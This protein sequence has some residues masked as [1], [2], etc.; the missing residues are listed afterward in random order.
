M[1][2]HEGIVSK[3]EKGDSEY[4]YQDAA[5]TRGFLRFGSLTV[6]CK[7]ATTACLFSVTA[8]SLPLPSLG[9]VEAAVFFFFFFSFSV[10]VSWP[11]PA[12]IGGRG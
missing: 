5:E 4:I 9:V 10:V 12:S 1:Y 2:Q 6:F 11:L 7:F 3:L 8:P